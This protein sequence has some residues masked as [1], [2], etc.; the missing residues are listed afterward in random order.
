MF[1]DSRDS[2][3]KSIIIST[4][5]KNIIMKH[6]LKPFWRS[7]CSEN[8]DVDAFMTEVR[9]KAHSEF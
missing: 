2:H 5:N 1:T 8:Q 9:A 3:N 4:D 6:E 7:F